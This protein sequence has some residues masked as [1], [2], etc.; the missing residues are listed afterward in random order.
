MDTKRLAIGLMTGSSMDGIDAAILETDGKFCVKHIEGASA[1][2]TDGFKIALR[3]AEYVMQKTAGDR[4]KSSDDFHIYKYDF[5]AKDDMDKI[6]SEFEISSVDELTFT[7][8]EQILTKKHDDLVHNL[9]SKA[10]LKSSEIEVIGFHGQN[11][12]HHPAVKTI[13]IGD[14][15]MLSDLTNITVVSNFRHNDVING[16]QGAPFAPLYHYAIAG[17]KRLMPVAILNCGGIANITL[18]H[19]DD[20]LDMIAYDTGPGN[21]LIDRYM[22]IISNNSEYMDRDGQYGRNGVVDRDIIRLLEEKSLANY[23][24]NFFDKKP[25]KSL[26]TRHF[27][28][29]EEIFSLKKEDACATLEYFTAKSIV[30][31][32]KLTS[33]EPPKKY[34]L[35]GGGWKNPVIYNFLAEILKQEVSTECE[36]LHADDIG[37]SNQFMEAEIFAYLAIRNLNDQ[38]V[39]LPNI[40]GASIATLSDNV[41]YPQANCR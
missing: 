6:L 4:K 33:N 32:L 9:L 12:Y 21:V 22:R 5:L 36:I 1:D 17:S 24:G 31:S 37:W 15:Q 19:N 18:I 29:P 13:Q 2:Y 23:P 14:G 39:S 20:P 26:D 41:Y 16:G 30:D 8:I 27:N 11:L 40:T 3:L 35:A 10:G 38:P 7:L 34:I 28:L 25:P